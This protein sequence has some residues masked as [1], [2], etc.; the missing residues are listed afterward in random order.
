MRFIGDIHGDLFS[1][2]S[3]INGATESVQIGDFGIGFLNDE[4]FV[5][6]LHQDGR[7]KFI[8]GNHDDPEAC[9]ERVGWISDGTFDE[10][11]SIFYVGGAW[12]IDWRFRTPGYTWW[13]DEELSDDE[14]DKVMDLY[15]EKKPRVMITHD[16]P[17]SVSFG[18]FIEGSGKPWFRTRTAEWLER[19]FQAHK[20]EVWI[21]GHWHIDRD[22][23]IDGTR[24][25]CLGINSHLDLKV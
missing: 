19:M 25:V 18:M 16:A 14:F 11:R 4:G 22:E 7:H 8:R 2:M 17:E 3:I 6:D 1:Y 12:S 13:I 9:K 21:F 24:F 10:E 5:D 15:V 20:P 23:M